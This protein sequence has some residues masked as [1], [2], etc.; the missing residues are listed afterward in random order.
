[1]G[2]FYQWRYKFCFMSMV[3]YM[4][5]LI[6]IA[7]TLLW[8]IAITHS[9][10]LQVNDN[11]DSQTNQQIPI[12]ATK[13][14]FLNDSLHDCT[15]IGQFKLEKF[16]A[17]GWTKVV[18]EARK[19]ENGPPVAFK[20]VHSEGKD[21]TDCSKSETLLHCHNRAVDKLE[22]EVNLFKDLQHETFVKMENYCL[23]TKGDNC[24]KFA[25][26]VVELGEPL[27]NLR[28]LQLTWKQRLQVIRDLSRLVHFA[29]SSPL[30]TLGLADLRRPQFVLVDNR[31]KFGDLDDIII[32]DPVC[33]AD[34]HCSS[35]LFTII[36]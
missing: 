33:S 35:K 36:L 9:N 31:L 3:I 8:N 30:G 17:T 23:K 25:A 22:Q 27:T 32:G 5:T 1:M 12:C 15:N 28:L 2:Y 16:I 13:Q 6:W 20:S 21:V 4:S 10:Q 18:H 29:E 19:T 7:C 24:L 26:V 34:S 14:K 11:L